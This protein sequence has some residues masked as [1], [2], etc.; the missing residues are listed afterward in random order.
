MKITRNY[1]SGLSNIFTADQKGLAAILRGFAIDN[2]RTYFKANAPTS[3]TDSTT[4]TA[5]AA[6]PDIHVPLPVTATASLGAATTNTNASLVKLKNDS[7]VYMS[8]LNVVRQ[9]LGLTLLTYGEGT[10]ASANV[11]AALDLSATGTATL[12]AVVNHS[13]AASAMRNI[14]ANIAALVEGTNEVLT[15]FGQPK[16]VSLLKGTHF[17]SGELVL[18]GVATSSPDGTSSM[19]VTDVTA[20][21]LAAAAAFATIAKQFNTYIVALEPTAFTDSTTGT[22]AAALAANATPAAAAG[23]A[24]TS[25]PKAGFDTQLALAK[26]AIAS[27]AS[28]YNELATQ[29]GLPLIVD[30]SGGAVSATLAA[31]SHALSAVDGSSGTSA[32]DVVTAGARMIVVDNALSSLGALIDELCTVTNVSGLGT[33]ALGGAVSE[34]IAAIPATATGVGGVTLVTMLNSAVNTWLAGTINNISTLAAA[35]NAANAE[36]TAI[37]FIVIAG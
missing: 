8:S 21:L 14:K 4:G 16:L 7:L 25:A 6:V 19:L 24:T 18:T 35:L 36:V 31:M 9:K 22:A 34:V 32:L 23:A 10:I 29:N 13:S 26:N 28:T 2:V 17:E 11:L 27:L 5:A 33:D 15:A 20:Y 12:T 37:P 1:F 3:L 30:N